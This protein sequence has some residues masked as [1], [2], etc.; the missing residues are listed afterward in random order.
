MGS[1]A[2]DSAPHKAPI[3]HPF[4]FRI[5]KYVPVSLGRLEKYIQTHGPV[6][7]SIPWLFEMGE[8]RGVSIFFFK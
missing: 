8:L 2:K 5:K 4:L 7:V 6:C 3:K 1:F